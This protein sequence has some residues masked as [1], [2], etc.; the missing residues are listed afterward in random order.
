MPDPFIGEIRIFGFNFAPTGWAMC[1]GQLLPIAQYTALFSLL[2]TY[3]G[4]NG[5]SNFGLPDLRA[6]VPI[7]MGQGAGLSNYVL[8]QLGGAEAVALL[9]GQLPAHSH[10]VNA[11]DG[12]PV[13]TRPAGAVP[14][15]ASADIYASAPDGTTVM[16]AGMIA[17]AG[18]N[19]PH[20]NMQPYLTLNFCIALQGVF[21][22]RS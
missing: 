7:S 5:T 1:D 17:S 6:R 16:N 21:P 20:P 13:L 19:Q 9:A 2:G 18:G 10:S 8:G 14:A 12:A 11:S 15:R 3:F 4:G 22:P